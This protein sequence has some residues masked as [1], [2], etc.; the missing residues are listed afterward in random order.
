MKKLV[1]LILVLGLV[2]YSPVISAT[3]N[4]GG[5]TVFDEETKKGKV[6][7]CLPFG[8]KQYKPPS[9]VETIVSPIK[10]VTSLAQAPVAIFRGP[11]RSFQQA[12]SKSR[13]ETNP[14]VNFRYREGQT[15]NTNITAEDVDMGDSDN[16][17]SV[18]KISID[19]QINNSN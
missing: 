5:V 19:V 15:V 9:W 10:D 16:V 6:E 18:G 8:N 4:N 13:K 3:I 7:I 17:A 12:T 11:E 2:S 14:C 1:S